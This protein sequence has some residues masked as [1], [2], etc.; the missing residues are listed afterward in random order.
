MSAI[1]GYSV[2]L[3]MQTG[4]DMKRVAFFSA[5]FS[6]GPEIARQ[7]AEDFARM[8]REKGEEV[9]IEEMRPAVGPH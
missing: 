6:D 3:R 1:L 9:V 2:S 8:R 5:S 4:D 7:R